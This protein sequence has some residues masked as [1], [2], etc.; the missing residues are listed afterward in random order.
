MLE[1]L[2]K[3]LDD[4]NAELAE[5]E[6]RRK[7][8]KTRLDSCKKIISTYELHKEAGEELMAALEGLRAANVPDDVALKIVLHNAGLQ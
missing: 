7:E 2:K 3:Q 5:I 8:L 6:C 1:E 4:I